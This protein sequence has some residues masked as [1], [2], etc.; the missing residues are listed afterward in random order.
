MLAPSDGEDKDRYNANIRVNN[1]LLQGLPKD[2][3]SLINHFTDAKD[4][5]DNVKMLLEGLELTKEDRESQLYDDFERFCQNKGETIHNYYVRFAKLIN[6]MRNIKMTMSK[7]QLNSKFVNNMLPE[8]GR[9]QHEAHAN[10]NKMML[11]RFTQHTVDPL[12]L[13]SN[14]S[15]QQYYSQS[16]TTPVPPSTH[17]PP[18][19]ADNTQLDS[20]LSPM[21]NIIE[22]LTNTLALLTQ[23]YKTY[24][25]QT[26]NQ[27]R[28]SSNIRNQA[29]VQD[30]RVQLVMG[31]L[32]TELGMSTPH[33]T[34]KLYFQS[35]L[36]ASLTRKSP[37][38]S[39]AEFLGSCDLF[40]WQCNKQTVVA[41]S[42]TE[43]EYVA[44]ASCCGQ[45]KTVN[46]EVQIQALV[47]KKKVII[48]ETSI[49][50]DL[51]LADENGTECLPNATIFAE[52]ERMSAKT[53]T[54]NEFSSTMASAI[55]SP[56]ELGE[57][58][59]IPTDPQ[60]TPI[61][62]QPSTSQPQK[63]QPR[64]KHR[65]DTKVPQPSGSIKPITNEAANEEHVPIHS[66]DPLLSGE[67]RLKL[68][69]LMELYTNLSQRVLDLENT[70][71]SQ[72][73]KIAKLKEKVKKLERRNKSR[74]PRLKRLRKVGR[75]ERIESSKDESLGAQEDASKQG[76]K[77]ADLNADAEVTLVD[78][79]Q[80]RNDDNLMFDTEVFD[81]EEV[82]VEKTVST[83]EVTTISATTTT[84]D[85]LTLA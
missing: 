29:T 60:Q 8:W 3:Y 69:E 68:N 22:N 56:E 75:T 41:N 11:D 72:A 67:D 85:E 6:D 43:A 19:F 71:T 38:G 17:V 25:P 58:S 57:G 47:D 7:M 82:E 53:T 10:E 49:R 62:I 2:I 28:T 44:V 76:R 15:H 16:S 40:S 1:I 84:V 42:T 30:G 27:L 78:E 50:R 65:K 73:A 5:W 52:L 35:H 9:F 32:K 55:I 81:E 45:V 26:N 66:N 77:I 79:A 4:I 14:V 24:L 80:K 18:Y 74:T 46:G 34:S 64:R 31:E 51:Q 48:T 12:A 23:S 59:E 21:D 20:G 83:V 70:K 61:I 37:T 36:K 39:V 13:M 63:K 54:W 33:E